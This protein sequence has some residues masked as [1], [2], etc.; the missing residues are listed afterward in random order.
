MLFI[1]QFNRTIEN[2]KMTLVTIIKKKDY[3]KQNAIPRHLAKTKASKCISLLPTKNK[4]GNGIFIH[5]G[6]AIYFASSFW[7][8]LNTFCGKNLHCSKILGFRGKAVGNDI[9]Y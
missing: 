9:Q 1:L 3:L 5:T 2:I 4:N 7:G 6:S 8:Y